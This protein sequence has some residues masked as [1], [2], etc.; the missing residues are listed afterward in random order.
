M[1]HVADR[2][3]LRARQAAI[4]NLTSPPRIVVRPGEYNGLN[5]AAIS[6]WLKLYHF[7]DFATVRS[8]TRL[9]ERVDLSE[10]LVY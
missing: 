2:I 6:I 8:F 9:I 7:N 3:W 10:Y 1:E 5:V 4:R